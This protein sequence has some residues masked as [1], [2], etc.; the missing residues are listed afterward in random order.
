VTE[1]LDHPFDVEEII[2]RLHGQLSEH[3]GH[4]TL[5]SEMSSFLQ[6]TEL[7]DKWDVRT[8]VTHGE[9]EARF[10]LTLLTH[11]SNPCGSPGDSGFW[12]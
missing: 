11:E 10:E 7:H 2:I 12:A 9:V 5:V 6:D 8:H 3:T 1:L 4:Q